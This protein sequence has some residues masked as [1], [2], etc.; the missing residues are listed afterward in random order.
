MT[1][2][3]IAKIP[4][5]KIE[6]TVSLWH[7][8]IKILSD[9]AKENRHS[10][11]RQVLDAIYKEWG[12]RRGR[13]DPS[14][15]FDWPSTDADPD[16]GGIETKDWQE[17]GVL[18]FMGYTV[19]SMEGEPPRVRQHILSEIFIG[20][21]PPVFS[22]EYLDQ[23]DEPSTPFRLRKMAETIAALARNAHRRRDQ[24]MNAAIRDWEKDLEFLYWKYYV[25]KFQFDWPDSK[26]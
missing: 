7:S 13:V 25:E 11:A 2:G 1:M 10:E 19:G 5:M 21:I 23:W 14:E 6:E 15:M 24:N 22:K 4:A 18:K 26:M 9:P 17:I 20:T 8:A 12:R 3:I 16:T